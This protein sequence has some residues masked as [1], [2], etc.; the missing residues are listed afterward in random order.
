MT[1]RRARAPHQP[2][3]KIY[4]SPRIIKEVSVNSPKPGAFELMY[5]CEDEISSIHVGG[6]DM[7]EEWE[8]AFWS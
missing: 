8:G 3:E 2:L 5:K 1:T 7:K 6:S 4:S